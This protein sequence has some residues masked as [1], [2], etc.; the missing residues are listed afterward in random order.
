M[1]P[2]KSIVIKNQPS[3]AADIHITVL[4]THSSN[5]I[6]IARARLINIIGIG[7][8]TTTT[9]KIRPLAGCLIPLGFFQHMLIL[10]R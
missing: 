5:R 6:V 4:K 10:L 2:D 3:M 9:N 1:T 8:F 7:L